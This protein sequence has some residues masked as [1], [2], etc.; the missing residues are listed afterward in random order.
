MPE[1]G[2]L[3]L[4]VGAVIRRPYGLEVEDTCAVRFFENIST[5]GHLR[6]ADRTDEAGFGYI[7]SPDPTTRRERSLAAAVPIDLDNDGWVDLV[8]INRRDAD[9]TSYGYVHVFRNLGNGS[10]EEIS[11]QVHGMADGAG[12]RDLTNGD[13]NDD[14]LLD[15]V[16][17]DGSVG[18]YEGMDNTR[19]Y[20][21]RTATANHWLNVAVSMNTEGSPA[22]GAKVS[23]Y[24]AHSGT[25]IGYDELRTDFSYRCKR[26]PVLHFGLGDA[27]AVDVVVEYRGAFFREAVATVDRTIPMSAVL[28]V[29]DVPICPGNGFVEHHDIAYASIPTANPNALSLDVYE[30]VREAGCPPAPVMIYVHGGA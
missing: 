3:D 25:L 23:V 29:Q 16:V 8:A 12:G 30:P 26:P 20:L 15:V 28:E 5:P 19:V 7:N 21:N 11:P 22:I 27:S 17:M 4:F 2:D 9:K 10:F 6:F 14:G 13:L 24:D 18:G 1:P